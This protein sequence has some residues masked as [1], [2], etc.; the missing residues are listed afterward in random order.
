M[1]LRFKNE[2]EYQQWVSWQSSNVKQKAAKFAQQHGNV[3][4]III[5]VNAD[6][7]QTGEWAEAHIFIHPRAEE[8]LTWAVADC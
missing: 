1:I 5:V 4:P 3:I 7:S 6:T 2:Q 8:L